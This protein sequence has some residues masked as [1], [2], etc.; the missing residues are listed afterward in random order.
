MKVLIVESNPNLGQLWKAH[1][2]RLGAAP[3]VLALSQDDAIQELMRREWDV[4]VLNL[5]LEDGGAM[6]V[7]DYASYRQPNAKVIIINSTSFFSDGSIFQ[8]FANA[9]AFLPASTKPED[10]AATVAHYSRSES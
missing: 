5:V 1:V 6:S 2:E 10:L 7:S 8:H 3:A 9:R 4:I